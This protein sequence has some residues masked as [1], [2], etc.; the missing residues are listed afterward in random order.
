M[1]GSVAVPILEQA[2]A[3]AS[4]VEPGD[5]ESVMVRYAHP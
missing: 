1:T 5:A 4:T 3:L 2:A